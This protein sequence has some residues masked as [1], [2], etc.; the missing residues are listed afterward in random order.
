MKLWIGWRTRRQRLAAQGEQAAREQDAAEAEAARQRVL[1]LARLQR[2][3]D[4]HGTVGWNSR[5][6]HRFRSR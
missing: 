2:Y 4:G 5:C 1:D 3:D 6:W